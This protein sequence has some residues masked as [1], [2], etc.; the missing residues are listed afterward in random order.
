MKK[1][2]RRSILLALVMGGLWTAG[3]GDVF[4]L[5]ID[6]DQTEDVFGITQQTETENALA[7]NGV[8]NW[9]SGNS[10]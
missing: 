6:G 7:E 8:L 5:D 9:N 4:A 1:H 3:M 10:E 2:V